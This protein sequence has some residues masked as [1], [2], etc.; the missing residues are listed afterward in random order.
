LFL[1]PPDHTRLRR[2]V[3]PAFSQSAVAAMRADIEA[4]AGSLL[5]SGAASVDLVRDFAYPLP[6]AVVAQLLGI[7]DAD[8]EQVAG[9]SQTLTASLDVPPP[10]KL[11]DVPRGIA[12]IVRRESHPVAAVRASTAICRY[13]QRRI[14]AS[15]T[16]PATPFC[17]T[18]VRGIADGELNNDEAAATWVMMAIAGHETTA[19][20]IGNAVH[21][22]LDQ[23]LEVDPTLIPRAVDECLRYD[24]PVPHT[25]RVAHEDVDVGGVTIR[26][27]E[28]ALLLLAAANRDPNAF[29]DPDRL[30]LN[31]RKTPSH[32]G[33]AHG[34]HFCVGA[35]LARL[36]M[37]AAL[38]V[39]LPRIDV[40]AERRPA[41]RRPTV[42]VRGLAELPLTLKQ[43]VTEDV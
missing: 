38:N 27:G 29:P 6:F 31:R 9:W 17:E 40:D 21:A 35:A 34:I 19:N 26:R 18:L 1:D 28:V 2:V 5:P 43:D 14:K 36:E 33:F 24:T 41:V 20:L 42:A 30:D 12:A 25:P 32:V 16:A 15:K 39:V 37:E 4:I 13:A 23:Q 10:V 22:I 3:A 11:R 8:R 7:P